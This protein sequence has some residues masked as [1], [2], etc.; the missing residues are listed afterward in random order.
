MQAAVH[1]MKGKTYRPEK[2]IQ[3]EDVAAV[4]MS[5]LNLPRRTEVTDI[6]IRPLLRS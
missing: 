4:V 3:P 2:L 6:T 5:A 1:K